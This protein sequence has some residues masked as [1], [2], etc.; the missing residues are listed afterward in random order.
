MICRAGTIGVFQIESWAQM[1]MPPRFT[2]APWTTS[3][4]RWRWS[5]QGRSRAR[6]CAPACAG[7][8]KEPVE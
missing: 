8:K 2:P 3:P 6:W 5:G 7:M 4:S 1:G